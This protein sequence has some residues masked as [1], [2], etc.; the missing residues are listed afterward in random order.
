MISLAMAFSR[1]RRQMG[2]A[3]M[4]SMFLLGGMV[5]GAEST[6]EAELARFRELRQEIARHDELYFQKAAPV[7]SDAEYDALKMKLRDLET[8]LGA[9][10]DG[11]AV[12][13]DRTGNFEPYRHRE[14]MLSLGKAYSDEEV[15]AFAERVE[16]KLA[17]GDVAFRV[18]LK[19]DGLAV[20]ITYEHG[21]LV[22]AVTRGDGATGEDVTANA[23]RRVR[24]WVEQLGADGAAW[25]GPDVVEL[26]GEI[27]LPL[28]EFARLNKIRA[29]GG[30]DEFTHPR[31]AAVGLLRAQ[32]ADAGQSLAL[33]CY[34]WGAWTP[35]A[36]RPTSLGEFRTR[37]LAWG[38]PVVAAD[39][40]ATGA[41]DLRAAVAE[42]RQT[43]P[44]FG[45]PVDGV[46]IKV[47]QVA[48]QEEL[49]LAPG[50]PR[51]A[52]AR[53]FAPQ[54]AA[55]RLLG[56]TWQVGRSGVVTPVAELEPV[57]LTGSTV[58][59]ATLHNAEEITR[60]DLRIGDWVWVEKAGEIIPAITGVDAARRTGAEEVA[61]RTEECPACGNGLER[62]PSEAA[63]RCGNR[64]CPP[65]VARRLAHFASPAALD[66]RG[67][68]QAALEAA[69]ER[70]L[71]QEPADFYRLD[72]S[73][74]ADLPGMGQRS[75]ER[76][77]AA[78]AASRGT[79]RT[80]GARLIC[81]LGLPGVGMAAAKRLAQAAAGI[82]PLSHADEPWLR[83]AA[84]LGEA[85]T[86][87]L[88]AYLRRDDVAAE[89]AA[90]SALG[91]GH[92]WEHADPPDGVFQGRIV[93]VTGTLTY[94][95]RA[96]ITRQLTEAGAQVANEVTPKTHLLVAGIA[97]GSKLARAREQGVEV[98]DEA[99]L[100]RRLETTGA[101]APE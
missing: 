81:G 9:D 54:R 65:Q 11:V 66:I 78:V 99:E 84:G 79:A 72:A 60:R 69:V 4:T 16:A 95:T 23:R 73:Q 32:D 92:A 34:G 87:E 76:V 13:D 3:I 24:G 55:T 31:N 17:G 12:G 82:G 89:L 38:L 39:R 33:V 90:L 2:F 71:M 94:W 20:S 57:T 26:R 22:R 61:V 62:E 56:I 52:V 100:A 8:K 48:E 63:L 28:A 85:A 46:V 75:A 86:R 77:V 7:I 18:E 6:A 68:G 15:A 21:H 64:K 96:E 40:V 43:G 51:W 1:I 80:N 97:A 83:Q 59:R 98:I 27:F 50:A 67:L 58:A 47:E 37:L 29:A 42:I 25:A 53:K 36:E 101:G 41:A 10:V 5:A 30:E 35:A 14:P 45:M 19:Y 44:K 49:G 91:V 88:A 74:W 93:V 70:G